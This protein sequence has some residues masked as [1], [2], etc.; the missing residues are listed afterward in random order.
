MYPISHTKNVKIYGINPYLYHYF[1][2]FGMQRYNIILNSQTFA[3][4]KITKHVAKHIF[5][6]FVIELLHYQTVLGLLD[7]VVVSPL[8]SNQQTSFGSL[9]IYPRLSPI[10][11]R[12]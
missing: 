4:K 9:L 5:T 12:L 11:F 7:Y 3:P 6:P 10:T 2:T 1:D 8:E